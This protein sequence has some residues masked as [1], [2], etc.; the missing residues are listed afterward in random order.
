[1]AYNS[2]FLSERTCPLLE[3]DIFSQKRTKEDTRNFLPEEDNGGHFLPEE[4]IFSQKRTFS[5]RRGHFLPGEDITLNGEENY[6]EPKTSHM[7]SALGP[8]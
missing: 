5:P 1:M 7:T 4:D 3:E 2:D 6:L 8:S